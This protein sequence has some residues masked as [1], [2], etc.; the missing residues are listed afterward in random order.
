MG[1]VI[2]VLFVDHVQDRYKVPF[3]QDQN[4]TIGITSLVLISRCG[5]S[6]FLTLFAAIC[7]YASDCHVWSE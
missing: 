4:E 5:V 6:T 3:M 1:S 7:V 2:S